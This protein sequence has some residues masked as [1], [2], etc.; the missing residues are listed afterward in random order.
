MLMDKFG[1]YLRKGDYAVGLVSGCL[2]QLDGDSTGNEVHAYCI[3]RKERGM[4]AH[5]NLQRISEEE[6]MYRILKG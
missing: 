1:K 5:Y 3:T 4:P 6:A 2:Y